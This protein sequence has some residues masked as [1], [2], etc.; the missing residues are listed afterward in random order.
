MKQQHH[1]VAAQEAVHF[2]AGLAKRTGQQRWRICIT[3]PD[4]T[5]ETFERVGGSTIDHSADGMDR[6]GLGGRVRVMPLDQLE[7]EAA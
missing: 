3:R 6:A 2:L 1:H 4:G 7:G 5:S